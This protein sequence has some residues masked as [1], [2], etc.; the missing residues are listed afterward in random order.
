MRLDDSTGAD[1]RRLV[2]AEC[3]KIAFETRGLREPLVPPSFKIAG[4]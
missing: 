2:L 3:E 4:D 1:R